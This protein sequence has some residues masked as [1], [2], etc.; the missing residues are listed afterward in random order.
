MPG[1]PLAA[2]GTARVLVTGGTGAS[3]DLPSPVD[4][5]APAPDV[6]ISVDGTPYRGSLRVLVNARGTLNLVNRVDLEEYL[7]G[8]VP[9]E[10]GPKRFDAIEGLKAQ[11]VAARTYAY[12]HRGQF[13]TEGYDLCPGPKCQAYGGAS[14]EDPLSTAAVDGTRGLVLASGGTVRRRALRLH[15]RGRHGKRRER[16]LRRPGAVPGLGRVRGASDRGAAGGRG[17]PATAGRAARTPS[18][19]AVT[20]CAAGRPEGRRAAPPA[21]RRRRGGRASRDREALRPGCCP[22]RFTRRSWP[23][24]T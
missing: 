24:S 14:V 22:R 8:V 6:R 4:V 18:S 12:A 20:S 17:A 19:G 23:P 11:A 1:A 10:M 16:F 15:L 21:S 13:E 9:A 3:L 7:Y 5:F 2:A